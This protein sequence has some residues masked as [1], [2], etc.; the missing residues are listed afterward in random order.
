MFA[1]N[2]NGTGLRILHSFTFNDNSNTDGANPDAG[3]ILSGSTLY[4]TA[5][6]GGS[7]NAGTVFRLSFPPELTITPSR[8]QCY[9]DVANQ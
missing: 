7:P 4:G 9:F 2:T 6:L 1:I 3:L 5:S 8:S